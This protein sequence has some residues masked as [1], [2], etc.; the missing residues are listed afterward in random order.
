MRRFAIPALLAG[1]VLGVVTATAAQGPPPAP[2]GQADLPTDQV[3]VRLVD[4]RAP[5]EASLGASAGQALRIVRQLDDGS[6]VLSL[7]GR[8]PLAAVKGVTQRLS[9]RQ[10]VAYAEP[11]ALMVATATPDD[12]RYPEQWHYFSPSSG[13]Y[14]ANLPA[15]WD[16]TTGS[17]SVVV[18]VIDTGYRPHA[19][20]TG[21]IVPG[22]DFIGDGL[23]A[24]D[25]GAR[26]SD[27]SD[28]GDWITSA[29]SASGYFAGCRVGD[30]SWHGT[31]V[32]GTIGAATNNNL[33]VAGIDWN[34]RVQPLRVLGKCGGYTTDIADA[35]RWGAGL[36]VGGLPANPTPA[37][38]LNLSLG[39]S[40]ACAATYQSAITA[41]VTA[42][43]VVAVAAGNS[44]ANAAN[45]QP[46]SCGGVLTI[47]ATGRTGNRAYYSNFGSVVEVAAPG[48]D[49]QVGGTVLS[50]LNAGPTTPGADSYAFYQGTSMATP[51]VAGVVSLLFA[52]DG[53]LTPSQV[54]QLLQA[55]VTPFPAGSTCN[56]SSCGAGILNAAAA[57]AAA[58]GTPPPPPPPPPPAPPG[59]FSKSSPANGQTRR[60]TK[61]TLSWGT[62]SG[63]SGYRYCYD[64]SDDNSCASWTATASTSAAITGL[65]RATTYY[66]QVEATTAT[67]STPAD[68]GA[69]WRFTTR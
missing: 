36:S 28:P 45:Y 37:K 64:T 58:G 8:Q 29:E 3:V 48:G 54:T 31:H 11:D 43:T 21:R 56:T 23:V 26:D 10:D 5:D 14:G 61:L 24:N 22:Y 2:P 42:G 47:A 67:L 49:S 6:W 33:G 19:D 38:V 68:G 15:A 18:G 53:T 32:A 7:N 27:A 20:L 69:Y 55:N 51:H 46:A 66:W 59:A 16:L 30:S 39:G 13:S 50:T 1:L 57:V 41:A 34:A 65:S 40:G 9:A 52:R 63:A 60:Q 4:G 35:I 44:N 12:P 17:S 25:G 62:S